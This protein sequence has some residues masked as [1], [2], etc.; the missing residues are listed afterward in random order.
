[1]STDGQILRIDQI[2]DISKQTNIMNNYEQI[3]YLQLVG[4]YGQQNKSLAY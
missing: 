4:Q 1:M 2:I 3:K